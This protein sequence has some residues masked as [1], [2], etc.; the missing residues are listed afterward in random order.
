MVKGKSVRKK[1]L[2]DGDLLLLVQVYQME[3]TK[4]DAKIKIGHCDSKRLEWVAA[5]MS[6]IQMG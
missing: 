4:M 2:S 6:E 3:L 1:P 5:W